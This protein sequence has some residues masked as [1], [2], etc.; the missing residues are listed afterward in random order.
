MSKPSTPKP[1]TPKPSP[2]VGLGGPSPVFTPRMQDAQARN[3]DPYGSSSSDSTSG[4]FDACVFPPAFL[5]K[6]TSG[7]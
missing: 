5:G 1:S 2:S 4:R 6:T 7:C 3:K